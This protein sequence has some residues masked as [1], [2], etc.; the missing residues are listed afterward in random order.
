MVILRVVL[1]F[2]RQYLFEHANVVGVFRLNGDG[3]DHH[4]FAEHL[5]GDVGIAAAEQNFLR[6]K[7]E[8]AEDH[9]GRI[10]TD[11]HRKNA[12]GVAK[13]AAC[14]V[15]QANVHVR[16]RFSGGLVDDLPGD[17]LTVDLL[18]RPAHQQEKQA[19]RG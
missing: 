14:Q 16:E 4:V 8:I 15:F 2:V 13:C 17:F 12:A 6:L 3:L 5:N 11:L 7:A 10:R 9:G 19:A 18:G 1:L